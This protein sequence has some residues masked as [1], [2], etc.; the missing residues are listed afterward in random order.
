MLFI[1]FATRYPFVIL[2]MIMVQ[3]SPWEPIQKHI[4]HLPT[5][6]F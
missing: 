1:F 3:R 2:C 5:R 4:S 6:G